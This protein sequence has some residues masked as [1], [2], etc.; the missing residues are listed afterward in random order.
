MKGKI[1]LLLTLGICV[2]GFILWHKKK[3]PVAEGPLPAIST[4][5]GYGLLYTLLGDEKNVSKVLLIKKNSA[6]LGDLIK[7]ISERAR[8]GHEFMADFSKA[9]K[10]L[11]LENQQLPGAELATRE[12]ISKY[13]E[14]QLLQSSGKEFELLLLLT[15]NEA[16]TYGSHLAGVVARNEPDAKRKEVFEQLSADL[17]ALQQR[18]MQMLRK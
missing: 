15:Q 11:D 18:V 13:K 4:N 6:E 5:P 7:A 10:T 1:A 14:K 12:S 2:C 8:R 9:D 17:A 3:N 16:L